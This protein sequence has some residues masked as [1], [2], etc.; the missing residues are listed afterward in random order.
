MNEAKTELL[1]LDSRGIDLEKF[2][3]FQIQKKSI[4]YLGTYISQEKNQ[5]FKENFLPLVKELKNDVKKWQDLK[6]NL[7]GRINL[8]KIMV[9]PKFLFKFE[10][11]PITPPKTFS[12]E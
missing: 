11:I 5:L 12:K 4:K 6:V 8:F 2:T 9:L 3:Q 7:I 1:A 10:T